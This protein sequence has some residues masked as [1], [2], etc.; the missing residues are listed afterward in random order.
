MEH[1][2]IKFQQVKRVELSLHPPAARVL[3]HHTAHIAPGVASPEGRPHCCCCYCC[4][5]SL[6]QLA[7]A[8]P[9]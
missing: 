6:L 9:V 1:T 3:A 2:N 7:A 5:S 4:C 8:P